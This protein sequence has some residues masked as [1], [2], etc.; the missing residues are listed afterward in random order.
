MRALIFGAVNQLSSGIAENYISKFEKVYLADINHK[1]AYIEAKQ[2]RCEYVNFSVDVFDENLVWKAITFVQ[3][4]HILNLVG[5]GDYALMKDLSVSA[6]HKTLNLN[7]VS[8]HIISVQFHRYLETNKSIGSI[9]HVSSVNSVSPAR[10]YVA[11][12]ASKA[13]LEGYVRASAIELAP[14]LRIYALRV[15]PVEPNTEGLSAQLKRLSV[16]F[17][18]LEKR[19]TLARDVAQVAFAIHRYF[20]WVTGD[21]ITVDGGLLLGNEK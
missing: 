19:L 20:L 7:F 16:P 15:G 17:H 12:S 10:G 1:N 4:T 8:A 14:C 13:A 9:I 2:V 11:Y 6:L 21:I 5:G 18:L 3:P